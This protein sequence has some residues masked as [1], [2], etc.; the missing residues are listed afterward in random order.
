V[1]G[2]AGTELKKADGS[3]T[4]FLP[5]RGTEPMRLLMKQSSGRWVNLGSI[6]DVE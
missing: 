5:Y 4:L 3:A 6:E 1:E 2:I